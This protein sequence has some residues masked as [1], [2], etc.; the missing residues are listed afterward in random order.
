MKGFRIRRLRVKDIPEVVEIL[1]LTTKRKVP[2]TWR[3]TVEKLLRR[4][5]FVGF[6]A[7]SQGKVLGFIIGEIK[8]IGFGL[9]ES[10]WIV[11][12]AVHPQH[13]GSGIGKALAERLLQ[14]FKKSGIEDIYTS[15]RWDAVDMLSFF[16]S[17][18][19]D[20]SEFINLGKHLKREEKDRRNGR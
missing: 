7:T 16:K 8:G 19:F 5:Y 4:R 12:I 18:G 10:G 6:A 15:V 13:M 2:A 3:T 1:E 9:V 17:I 14:F 20:R 11:V